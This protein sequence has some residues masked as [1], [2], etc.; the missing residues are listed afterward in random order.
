MQH[1]F[2]GTQGAFRHSAHAFR[3]SIA[4][5]VRLGLMRARGYDSL[6]EAQ[7]ALIV[8]KAVELREAAD[9]TALEEPDAGR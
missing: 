7:M 1:S 8:K 4:A 6:L 2:L 9:A 3:L 5:I